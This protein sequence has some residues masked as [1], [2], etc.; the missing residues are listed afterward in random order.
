M[1]S[2]ARGWRRAIRI[3]GSRP[4]RTIL[5]ADCRR[6]GRECGDED[7]R[8]PGTRTASLSSPWSACHEAAAPRLECRPRCELLRRGPRRGRR[9][10]SA[11]PLS[12]RLQLPRSWTYDGRRYK[13]RPGTYPA[14]SSGPVAARSRPGA[15]GSCSAAAPSHSGSARRRTCARTTAP[16]RSG[17]C[18]PSPTPSEPGGR[19]IPWDPTPPWV[20]A[21]HLRHARP[22][23]VVRHERHGQLGRSRI[24]SPRSWRHKAVITWSRSSTTRRALLAPATRGATAARRWS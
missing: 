20:D 9:V 15:T 14:G 8:L 1:S 24:R 19:N 3:A 2:K 7:S 6:R 5:P 16:S 18:A 23:R 13:L 17:V 10:Y 21:A 12:A 4:G 22:E 11:W